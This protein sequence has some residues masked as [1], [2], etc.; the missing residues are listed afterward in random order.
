MSRIS[1]NVGAQTLGNPKGLHGLYGDSFYINKSS[2]L[3]HISSNL[4]I[5]LWHS[6]S[7]LTF[8]ISGGGHGENNVL[9]RN[10]NVIISLIKQIFNLKQNRAQKKRDN[11]KLLRQVPQRKK[12]DTRLIVSVHIFWTA[13]LIIRIF[14]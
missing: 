5:V 4:P 14:K 2:V 10:G 13:S 9:A 6:F 8:Q 7:H 11:P 12:K 3:A 1:E